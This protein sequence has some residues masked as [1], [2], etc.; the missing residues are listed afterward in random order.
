MGTEKK[1]RKDI[2]K[3]S[4]GNKIPL[5]SKIKIIVA[6]LVVSFAA[7]FGIMAYFKLAKVKMEKTHQAVTNQVLHVA[8]LTT[9][10]NTYSDLVCIKKSGVGGMAKS[11]A[12]IKYSGVIRIG[13]E[14]ISDAVIETDKTGTEVDITIPHCEILDNTLVAQE[15]FD[16]RKSIFVPITTQEIFS[17]IETAMADFALSAERRGL[18]KEADQHLVELVTATVKGFGY[19]KINVKIK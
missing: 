11:Y 3:K 6:V 17:E 16:E 12:I 2:R 15:V 13:V 7:G 5:A 18:L 9:L 8:E 14:K 10:K 1:E 4:S 19:K